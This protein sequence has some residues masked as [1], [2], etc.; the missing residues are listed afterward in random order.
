MEKMHLKSNM[1]PFGRSCI[2][3]IVN[4]SLFDDLILISKCSNDWVHLLGD[5]SK[6]WECK[7]EWMLRT[8]KGG[9]IWAVD[10]H[11]SWTNCRK[12]L[13]SHPVQQGKLLWGRHLALR[14]HGSGFHWHLNFSYSQG[15][16]S[17]SHVE[18]FGAPKLRNP[19]SYRPVSLA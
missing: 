10:S 18:A 19:D 11:W 14:E 16:S 4:A 15:P 8:K 7:E 17:Q 5:Q 3:L 2:K 13:I 1:C 9:R 12:C 6:T